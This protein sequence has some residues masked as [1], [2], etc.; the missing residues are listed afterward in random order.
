MRFPA[1][2]FCFQMKLSQACLSEDTAENKIPRTAGFALS[3]LVLPKGSPTNEAIH[4]R[5]LWWQ[6]EEVIL[7]DRGLPSLQAG[8]FAKTAHRAVS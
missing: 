3:L 4:R 2:G 7:W 6:S 8:S 5:R 1:H